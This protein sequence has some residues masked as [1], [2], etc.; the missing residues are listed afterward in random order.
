MSRGQRR[1]V[2]WRQVNLT[3]QPDPEPITCTEGLPSSVY[4][5]YLLGSHTL[6]C[7]LHQE[8]RSGCEMRTGRMD[9]WQWAPQPLQARNQHPT[10]RPWDETLPVVVVWITIQVSLDVFWLY[11]DVCFLHLAMIFGKYRK[12]SYFKMW[13]F[14][15]LLCLLLVGVA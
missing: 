15:F 6:L 4:R 9:G 11:F 3:L 2:G 5:S 13:L 10:S 14:L 12:I 1:A 7:Q 8:I